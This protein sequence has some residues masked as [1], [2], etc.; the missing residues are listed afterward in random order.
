[1]QVVLEVGIEINTFKDGTDSHP[2]E[3]SYIDQ[4]TNDNKT[5]ENKKGIY[6]FNRHRFFSRQTFSKSSRGFLF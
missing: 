4:N 2:R 1:V 5:G 3:V 6:S